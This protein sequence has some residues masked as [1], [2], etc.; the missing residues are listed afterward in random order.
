METDSKRRKL[1]PI[2]TGF[3]AYFPLAIA[4]VARL[5]MEGNEKHN[6][7][8]KLAWNR[9]KSADELDSLARHLIDHAEA[10]D[11]THLR[12]VAWR[13]MAALQKACE[14]EQAT[15]AGMSEGKSIT[16]EH[17]PMLTEKWREPT[18]LPRHN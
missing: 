10:I 15:Q 16:V 11:I 6:S 13:S 7:G 14:Q 5:S 17:I 4:E 8:E 9:T 1:T 2:Y 3:M 18:P 12:A